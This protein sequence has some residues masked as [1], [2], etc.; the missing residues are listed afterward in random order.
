MTPNEAYWQLLYHVGEVHLWDVKTART[1]ERIL[2]QHKEGILHLL[3][4]PLVRRL[5]GLAQMGVKLIA[6]RFVT[7][8]HR[9]AHSSHVGVIGGTLALR[10]KA[11][12]QETLTILIAG[13]LHDLGH[14]A[15]AHDGERALKWERNWCH[16]RA[17]KQKI[18]EDPQ[19]RQALELMNIDPEM[20]IRII[21]EEG[22]LGM[23]QNIA[24]TLAYIL[25]DGRLAG[26]EAN[27][28]LVQRIAESFLSLDLERGFQVRDSGPLQELLDHR[29]R[30]GAEIYHLFNNQLIQKSLLHLLFDAIRSRRL[31]LDLIETGVDAQVRQILDDTYR[32][33][34]DERLRSIHRILCGHVAT[35]LSQHWSAT[36][37]PN[38]VQGGGNDGTLRY[39]IFDLGLH[40][41]GKEIPVTIEGVPR[42]LHTIPSAEQLSKS[43]RVFTWI[44]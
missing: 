16:E 5:T 29:A 39:N 12:D 11:S 8:Y 6:G 27:Q 38:G 9:L 4:S 36:I 10:L 40:L 7:Q 43:T 37:H 20:V 14:S 21:S 28:D 42:R 23:I 25:D 30:L 2:A 32:D 3:E 35:E 15:F 33:H 41:K 24:D 1:L 13:L 19:I 31:S 34:D 26:V 17:G 18:R 44:G 22:R